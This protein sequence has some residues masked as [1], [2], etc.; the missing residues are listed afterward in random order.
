VQCTLNSKACT[1]M[2]YVWELM[3]PRNREMS[4]KT[5]HCNLNE[6]DACNL[7]ID[8]LSVACFIWCKDEYGMCWPQHLQLFLSLFKFMSSVSYIAT[9]EQMDVYFKMQSIENL[10]NESSVNTCHFLQDCKCVPSSNQKFY[11]HLQSL[12]LLETLGLKRGNT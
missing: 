4:R 11:T 10:V 1:I 2:H 12:H 8:T 3:C 7:V 6:L 9:T 5:F